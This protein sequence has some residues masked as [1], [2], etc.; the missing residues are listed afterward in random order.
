M[1]AYAANAVLDAGFIPIIPH[2]SAV[3]ELFSPRGREF[4]LNLGL[5]QLDMADGLFRIAG[6]SAG[7]DVEERAAR[8]RNI[9]VFHDL[10]ELKSHDWAA[11]VVR[12]EW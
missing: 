8:Q 4:W 2:V 1:A 9:P 5:E 7:S 6:E 11:P 12:T 3:L 10:R